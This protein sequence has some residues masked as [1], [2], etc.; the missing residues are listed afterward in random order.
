[1]T[2]VGAAGLGHPGVPARCPGPA[3]G[4]HG[5]HGQDGPGEASAQHPS[6]GSRLSHHPSQE[7]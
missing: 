5:V 7:G 4:R 6:P 2:P 1:M 3:D